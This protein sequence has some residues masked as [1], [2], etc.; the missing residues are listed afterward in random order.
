MK[1]TTLK[2]SLILL[3]TIFVVALSKPAAATLQNC[4]NAQKA[5]DA[6][7]EFEYKSCLIL[8]EDDG[9]VTEEERQACQC[10]SLRIYNSCME[11]RGCQGFSKWDMEAVGCPDTN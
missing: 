9:G 10:R 3:L 11:S 7:N 6:Q 1:T 2:L 8:E 5:C 4:T